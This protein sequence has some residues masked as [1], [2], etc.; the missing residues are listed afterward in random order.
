MDSDR[1]RAQ[2]FQFFADV[3]VTELSS[4]TKLKGRTSDVSATGCFIDMLNP[5]PV[6]TTVRVVIFHRHRT[7]TAVGTVVLSLQNMGIG[8]T[9]TEVE[10]SELSVLKNWLENPV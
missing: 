2:R 9:F 8:V 3:E 10:T 4:E 7:F 6:D 1:R 5:S